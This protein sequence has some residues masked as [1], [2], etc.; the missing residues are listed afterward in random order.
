MK[1]SGVLCRYVFF[2]TCKSIYLEKIFLLAQ[3]LLA[4]KA[5]DIWFIE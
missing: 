4:M 2:H 5:L 1:P 3:E